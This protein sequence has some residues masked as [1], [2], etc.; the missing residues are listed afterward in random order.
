M[1][2]KLILICLLAI[3]F[4]GFTV[5]SAQ[6]VDL[7]V[8]CSDNG[9]CD[10]TPNPLDPLF[11]ASNILPG[12]SIT[13]TL[14]VINE[15][16]DEACN[17]TMQIIKSTQTPA[18]FA[19]QLFTAIA[20]DSVDFVGVHSG[21][22][23]VSGTVLQDLFDF[24]LIDMGIISA[25]ATSTYDWTV[26]FD[27]NAGNEF[28][29]AETKFDF[30]ME[31]SCGE[32]EGETLLLLSKTNDTNGAN[33]S[34]GDSVVYTLTV[35]TGDTAVDDVT[36]T[37]LLP[38]GFIYRPGSWTG[39]AT[40]PTYASPGVWQI[41]D[42]S[43]NQ[44]IVLTYIA[45]ISGDQ[46]PGIYQGLAWAE[47]TYLGSQVLANTGLS[48]E[49]FVWSDVRVNTDQQSGQEFGIPRVLG[50]QTEILPETGANTAWTYVAL[51]SLA[52]GSIALAVGIKLRKNA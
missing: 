34:P 48:P 45:D 12:D 31:F 2:I 36:V 23:A 42:M 22:E 28:Q 52:G 24:S 15:D 51:I 3:I 18:N 16:E 46:D 40:E 35:S 29:L 10:M 11:D 26:T 17:F 43:S 6:A 47:G 39:T 21:G 4:F 32:Q 25:G 1:R 27:F 19:Q 20:K 9:P 37:D 41:G 13:R 8:T 33:M 30:D 38:Y 50:A 7:V 5:S 14:T 49:Y 44:T